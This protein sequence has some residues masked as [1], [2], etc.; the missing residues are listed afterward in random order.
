MNFIDLESGLSVQKE[1]INAYRSDKDA[2]EW[3]YLLAGTHGDEPE[4]VYIINKM[5]DFFSLLNLPNY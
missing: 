5:K 1:I 4:G 3:I 2:K